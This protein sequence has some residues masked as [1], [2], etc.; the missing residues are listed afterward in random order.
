MEHVLQDTNSRTATETQSAKQA[1]RQSRKAKA[2]RQY[3]DL[4]DAVIR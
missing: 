3:I 1:K 2:K 4:G